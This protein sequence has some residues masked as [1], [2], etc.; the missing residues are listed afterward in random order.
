M[1]ILITYV[2][3]KKFKKQPTQQLLKKSNN[4]PTLVSTAHLDV[5]FGPL[6]W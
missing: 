2:V 5:D 1:L 3:P 6:E 4:M